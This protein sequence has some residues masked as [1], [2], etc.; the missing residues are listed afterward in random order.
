VANLP[1]W[2]RT[3]HYDIK[4]RAANGVEVFPNMALLLRSLLQ[5]RFSFQSHTESRELPTYDLLLTRAD[6]RPGPKM[7]KATLDCGTRT[8]ATPPPTGANG[9]PLCEISSG[10]GRLTVRGYSMARFA[11]TLTPFVQR[12]VIDKTDLTGGWNLD[13]LYTPDQPVALNGAIV[14]PNPDA[15]SLFTAVQEQLGLKLEASRGPV[16]VLV[17]D[18]IEKPT[19]D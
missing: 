14:P 2:T 5:D 12:P 3:E 10:P 19:E 13:V 18:R 8:T 9:E 1:D 6:R 16:D 11:Q 17:V 4:A 7:S 15:P